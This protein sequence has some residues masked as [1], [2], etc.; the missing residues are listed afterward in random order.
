MT[1]NLE[2][3]DIVWSISNLE[4]ES[5]SET[6]R[7]VEFKSSVG[8]NFSTSHK[9]DAISIECN[10]KDSNG[11]AVLDCQTD[12]FWI[13][14]SY[15][16]VPAYLQYAKVENTTMIFG[17]LQFELYINKETN[18]RVY[19]K[20]F[21]KSVQGITIRVWTKK[22]EKTCISSAVA[23]FSALTKERK[24]MVAQLAVLQEK[25]EQIDKKIDTAAFHIEWAGKIEGKQVQ[26]KLEKI[27]QII[28]S[29]K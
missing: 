12:Y 29:K 25:I 3:I 5:S 24:E 4:G 16:F 9:V 28:K 7:V 23:N 21:G 26:E 15:K 17:P 1:D 19:M 18:F 14:W 10:M 13:D 6:M 2:P 22:I 20:R 8:P 11:P 27:E